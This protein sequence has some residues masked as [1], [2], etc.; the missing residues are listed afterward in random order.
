MSV[1]LCVLAVCVLWLI[2]RRGRFRQGVLLLF[3]LAE[4]DG[5]RRRVREGMGLCLLY[6]I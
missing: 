4:R 2:T 3:F 6:L 1:G 5:M